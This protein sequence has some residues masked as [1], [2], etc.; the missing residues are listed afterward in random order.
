M[1]EAKASSST[2]GMEVD[3]VSTLATA[4][5]AGGAFLLGL[6][7]AAVISTAYPEMINP[8]TV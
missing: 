8:A 1:K 3:V 6:S 2:D 5:G 4:T 7:M